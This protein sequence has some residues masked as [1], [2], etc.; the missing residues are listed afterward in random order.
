MRNIDSSKLR[1]ISFFGFLT[2]LFSLSAF[3]QVG[4]NNTNPDANAVLDVT[5]TVANPGG[6]LLPRLALT[7]ANSPAPLTANV[8]GMVVYNTATA[9]TAP[10]NVTPGY[11][12]N[13]G[14]QWMRVAASTPSVEWKISGNDNTTAL[15]NYLGTTGA[16]N[17]G[18]RFR[19]FGVER[20]EITGGNA[21][22]IGRLQSFGDGTAAR[23]IYSWNGPTGQTMGMYR[24][25]DNILGFS[26][27]QNERLR[28]LANGQVSINQP[29]PFGADRF[30][31]Q[32]SN[33]QF[34]IN[35]YGTAAN[36]VGVYGEN[37]T[38]NINPIGVFGNVTRGTAIYGQSLLDGWGVAGINIGTGRGVIGFSSN[39]GYGVAGQNDASGIGVF[40]S[41]TL[42]GNA[43]WGQTDGTGRGVLG[44]SLANGTGIQGQVNGTGVAIFGTTANAGGLGAYIRNTGGGV[45][46]VTE[47][48]GAT[49][50]TAIGGSGATFN[51]IYGGVGLSINP[52]GTGLIGTGNNSTNIVVSSIGGGIAGSGTRNGVYG[53]AGNGNAQ[54][55]NQGNAAGA[56]VLDTDNDIT[57]GGN[58][59]MRASAI[60]AGFDSL[61]PL[62]VSNQNSYYGGYFSGGNRSGSPTYA[63][64]GLRY[65]ADTNGNS[66]VGIGT[67][68]YKIIGTGSVSTLVED[69]NNTPRVMFAPEA[70][71]VLFQDY[72][73]GK[74]I[75]G[76]VRITLDPILKEAIHVDA[77]N[78]LKV[79]VTLEGDSNGI[80]ITNKSAEGFTVKEL[81]NGTSNVSFS[82]QI[83]ATRADTKDRYGKIVSK[84]E[85]VRFP[86]GPKQ[87]ELHS[88]QL[89]AEK[90]NNFQVD[91]V[92]M[93]ETATKSIFR[94]NK[95][96]IQSGTGEDTTEIE[97]QSN[98]V[99]EKPKTKID[100]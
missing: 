91:E 86:Y 55:A 53:Y 87:L 75:N 16:N 81:Q 51:G 58:N 24:I 69:N 49:G 62:G 71:E 35:G 74:L 78:P 8:A 37:L 65:N 34:A 94:K 48:G 57:T 31:V 84:H 13:D 90:N 9:G 82:W 42:T 6:L 17:Q 40:G 73:I 97:T 45:G 100:N 26:T 1:A 2:L 44:F 72:G 50:I 92:S 89:T 38:M 99:S 10:N 36:G 23:P 7:A 46:L 29:A 21:A 56:F 77:Q 11:Y 22:N 79:F 15:N 47:G 63:Y 12:Y 64:V 80:Y 27:G 20:F 67:I 28:I 60:L 39:G 95:E 59:D 41:A 33:N 5:S 93:K 70:P 14:G 43:I 19:T 3:G 32:G 76:E 4:I 85:G 25:G 18:I 83:V 54:V 30:T 68:D 88:T 98:S 61:D 96:K 52:T 66:D